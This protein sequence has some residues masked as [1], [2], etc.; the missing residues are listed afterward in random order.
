MVLLGFLRFFVV[1]RVILLRTNYMSPRASR[2][3][4][5]Y[6]CR[7]DYLFAIKCLFKDSPMTLMSIV[8]FVSVVFFAFGLRIAER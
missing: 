4:R 6:G 8:F 3:C 1:V 2:N 5:M 7:S